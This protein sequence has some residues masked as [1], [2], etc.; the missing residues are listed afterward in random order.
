[1]IQSGLYS[2]GNNTSLFFVEY[3]GSNNQGSPV[4]IN[5]P[6]GQTFALNDEIFV[7]GW[8]SSNSNYNGMNSSGTYG[9]FWFYDVTRG[10]YMSGPGQ[11]FPGGNSFVGATAEWVTELAYSGYPYIA[12]SN[13]TYFVQAMSGVGYDSSLN[14]HTA[15]GGDPYIFVEQADFQSNG[16]NTPHNEVN[17]VTFSV[18]YGQ[19]YADNQPQPWVYFDFEN[20]L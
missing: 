5:A 17:Y 19:R 7:E 12:T 11:S 15:P 20:N 3:I 16:T 14:G 13:V 9:C 1:M 4:Y 8:P 2:N 6:S 10:W 18:P